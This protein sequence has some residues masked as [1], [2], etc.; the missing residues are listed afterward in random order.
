MERLS[1]RYAREQFILVDHAKYHDHDG[2]QTNQFEAK[3]MTIARRAKAGLNDES[4]CIYFTNV[5]LIYT[6]G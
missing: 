1:R 3:K 2:G 5:D 4:K 6:S